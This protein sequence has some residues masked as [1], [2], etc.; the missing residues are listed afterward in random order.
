MALPI[1]YK[2]LSLKGKYRCDLYVED[3]LVLE[4]K[5][6][7]E[8]LPIHQAQ[9]LTYMRILKAPKGMIINFNA[10]KIFPQGQKTLVNNLFWQLPDE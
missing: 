7:A 6:V 9:V 8:I 5:A 1:R 2:D 4:H 10:G 3:C